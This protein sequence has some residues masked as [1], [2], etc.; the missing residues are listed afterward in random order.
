MPM[1][2]AYSV[3]LSSPG[4]DTY[5]QM[6]EQCGLSAKSV[7]AAERGLRNSLFAV[8]GFFVP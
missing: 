7:E 6:R 3:R 1:P 5:R 8:Q 2:P 4:V